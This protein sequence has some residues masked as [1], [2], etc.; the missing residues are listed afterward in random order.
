MSGH[1]DTL[2][3]G[4][5][6]SRKAPKLEFYGGQPYYWAWVQRSGKP[7]TLHATFLPSVICTV[8]TD[9]E[10]PLPPGLRRQPASREQIGGLLSFFFSLLSV[11]WVWEKN[12]KER[13]LWL[14][15]PPFSSAIYQSISS[16]SP[17]C[18]GTLPCTKLIPY[19]LCWNELNLQ[20]V[21]LNLCFVDFTSTVTMQGGGMVPL[22]IS[23]HLSF[24]FLKSRSYFLL[25]LAEAL[26]VD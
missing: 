8:V 19:R 26:S 12:Q 20:S 15:D 13:N 11:L 21:L 10:S 17:H 14:Y 24:C 5:K 3:T 25:A 9:E 22:H 18:L 6:A 23:I 1:S 4:Q 7:W 16:L 2:L